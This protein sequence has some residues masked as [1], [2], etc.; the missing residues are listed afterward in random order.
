LNSD[1]NIITLFLCDCFNNT[2]LSVRTISIPSESAG[3]IRTILEKQRK[4][5]ENALQTQKQ[6]EKTMDTI[7]TADMIKKTTMRKI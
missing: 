2:L 5:Y 4:T 7:I 1:G 3:R 6:I